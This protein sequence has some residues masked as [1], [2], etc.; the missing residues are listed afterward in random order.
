MKNK[1]SLKMFDQ[2]SFSFFEAYAYIKKLKPNLV[3]NYSY[4]KGLFKRYNFINQNPS[5]NPILKSIKFV[6]LKPK[7]S[8]K[9]VKF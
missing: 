9:T 1:Q 2:L 6:K 7:F 5:Q 8:E 3:P 4:L